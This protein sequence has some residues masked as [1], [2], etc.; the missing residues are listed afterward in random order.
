MSRAFALFWAILCWLVAFMLVM[1][2]DNTYV[3]TNPPMFWFGIILAMLYQG[4]G[5]LFF[6]WFLR[7]D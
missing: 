5:L 1:V 7:K 2:A 6:S 4:I 3:D